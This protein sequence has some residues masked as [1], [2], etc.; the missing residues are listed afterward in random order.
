MHYRLCDIV[1]RNPRLIVIEERLKYFE[2]VWV[3]KAHIEYIMNLLRDN[4]S[5]LNDNLTQ[6]DPL[7]IAIVY[8]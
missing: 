6:E 4:A 3:S 8:L 2:H 1:M 5:Y 7:R